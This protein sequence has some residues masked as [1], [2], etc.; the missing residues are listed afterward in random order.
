MRTVTKMVEEPTGGATFDISPAKQFAEKILK[1]GKAA[2]N[3]EPELSGDILANG[4]VKASD[5]PTFS[6]IQSLRSRLLAYLRKTEMADKSSP[7]VGVAKKTLSMIDES[8]RDGLGKFDSAL[9]QQW[10]DANAFYKEGKQKYYSEL[11]SRLIRTSEKSGRP[12]GIIDMVFQPDA[13]SNVRQVMEMADNPGKESFRRIVADGLMTKATDSKTGTVL[14]SRLHDALDGKGGF[15]TDTLK[16]IFTPD[17][18]KAMKGLANAL[19]VTQSKSARGTGSVWIE[20]TQAGAA[21]NLVYKGVSATPLSITLGPY[22]LGKILTSETGSKLLSEGFAKEAIPAKEA[23]RWMS[24]LVALGT[25]LEDRAAALSE[26]KP[27]PT[28][29]IIPIPSR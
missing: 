22:A 28:E 12:E 4:I 19:E 14:G 29:P 3:I 24:R 17:Q 7:G 27:D 8:T 23:A 15:G 16:E 18:V 10:D 25:P 11:M 5:N 1:T 26:K 2:G 13:A 6:E 20:L 21:W 9:L